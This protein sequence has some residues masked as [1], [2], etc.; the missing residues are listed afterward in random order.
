MDRDSQIVDL[1]HHLSSFSDFIEEYS[2]KSVVP[3]GTL[4]MMVVICA[5]SFDCYRIFILKEIPVEFFYYS[6]GPV[7]C[8]GLILVGI[9]MPRKYQFLKPT[10]WIFLYGFFASI[11]WFFGFYFDTTIIQAI[12]F[13]LLVI[14]LSQYIWRIYHYSFLIGMNA[15]FYLIIRFW[16]KPESF[17][18]K[19]LWMGFD[20]FMVLL[21]L[22]MFSVLFS[23]RRNLLEFFSSLKMIEEERSRSIYA[24][25]MGAL[26]EM[27]AGIAH[28]INNPLTIITGHADQILMEIEKG[29][30]FQPKV[31]TESAERVILTAKRI[32]KIISSLK[33]IA[34]EA[35]QEVVALHKLHGVIE[36]TMELC[37][38]RFH[39]AG[40]QFELQMEDRDLHIPCRAVAISQV[41][42]N[43]F[44]NS[45]DAIEKMPKKWVRLE[46]T[47]EA[48]WVFMK[49]TDCGPGIPE[50]V[51]EKI[52][53][54]F[55]TTKQIG[56][57][58]GLGLSISKG[59]IEEHGGRLYYDATSPN[60]CFV[61]QLPL[62]SKSSV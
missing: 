18:D 35:G 37:R 1:S 2:K 42:L 28:E 54:P 52:M 22:L 19:T 57:G 62:F 6:L 4:I 21:S 23:R 60:T 48:K 33:S 12:Y 59:L 7:I 9:Y 15:V 25:K 58:T 24:S 49:V 50:D 38:N 29:S 39:Q 11:L 36:D 31:I 8:C 40:I 41:L 51:R 44:N 55:F 34:R 45:V 27:A 14:G 47:Q 13:A 53:Q 30:R 26:G 10:N 16:L 3:V 20:A 32:S 17:S 56:K 43:L 61:I 46:V 5:F